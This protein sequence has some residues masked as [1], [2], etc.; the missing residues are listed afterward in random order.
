[1]KGGKCIAKVEAL[2]DEKVRLVASLG[3]HYEVFLRRL[4]DAHIVCVYRVSLPQFVFVSADLADIAS[5]LTGLSIPADRQAD[6]WQAILKTAKP[7]AHHI[8]RPANFRMIWPGDT[9]PEPFNIHEIDPDRTLAPRAPLSYENES[10]GKVEGVY[11]APSMVTIAAPDHCLAKASDI[12]AALTEAV[13]KSALG[14]ASGLALKMLRELFGA[15]LPEMEAGMADLP[16]RFEDEP[17]WGF[18][19][20]LSALGVGMLRM[21][22]GAMSYSGD[23]LSGDAGG[24]VDQALRTLAAGVDWSDDTA[25]SYQRFIAA[26]GRMVGV[27]VARAAAR[28][29]NVPVE[30]GG[31]QIDQE[32]GTVLVS[33]NLMAAQPAEPL[34]DIL[35][36]WRP[37]AEAGPR[38]V[39]ELIPDLQDQSQRAQQ[40]AGGP[41]SVDPR[42]PDPKRWVD[43]VALETVP[44]R[45]GRH[46]AGPT[47]KYDVLAGIISD[48]AL[49][50][51]NAA[52]GLLPTAYGPFQF[53]PGDRDRAI[54]EADT[55]V[56]VYQGTAQPDK[57]PADDLIAVLQNDLKAVGIDLG[58]QDK[59]FYAY[60]RWSSGKQKYD[61]KAGDRPA[62]DGGETLRKALKAGNTGWAVREFQLASRY[63]NHVA[64]RLDAK[65]HYTDRLHVVAR[66]NDTSIETRVAS[67]SP[68]KNVNG[69]LRLCEA[70]NLRRWR[71]QRLRYP[72]VVVAGSNDD[73]H[74]VAMEKKKISDE[75][76]ITIPKSPVENLVQTDQAPSNGYRMYVVDRSGYFGADDQ[77]QVLAYY[78]TGGWG[79][80]A[81]GKNHPTVDLTPDNILGVP[82][83]D[84]RP[85]TPGPDE[86]E[87]ERKERERRERFL[88]AFRVLAAVGEVEARG[89]F[90]G[91][92]AYDSSVFSYPTFHHTLS[93]PGS[94]LNNKARPG[95][96]SPLIRWLQAP[97]DVFLKSIYPDVTA[98]TLPDFPSPYPSEQSE[99][100]EL[101]GK[102][103]DKLAAIYHGAF[104]GFGVGASEL[105][106]TSERTGIVTIS[107]LTEVEQADGTKID[108][109]ADWNKQSSAQQRRQQA[110]YQSYMQWFRTWH[111]IYRF[112][113]PLRQ[114]QALRAVLFAYEMDWIKRKLSGVTNDF[115][116]EKGRAVYVRLAVRGSPY[117]SV[118]D[119]VA[120]VRRVRGR[121]N[122]AIDEAAAVLNAIQNLANR[123]TDA[124]KKGK[125]LKL[126]ES[127]QNCRDYSATDIGALST[128]NQSVTVYEEVRNDVL[129]RLVL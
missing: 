71:F 24:E 89:H 67:N 51:L 98:D 115:R 101:R 9:I 105:E 82:A 93:L 44:F 88:S 54:D 122:I 84:W 36:L 43:L 46:L 53:L 119:A 113:A 117:F 66:H 100:E 17:D 125:I 106:Q 12:M 57:R 1:M 26:A 14:L 29:Q 114:D 48:D 126:H 123:E 62:S 47:S 55:G 72:V 28:L 25:E 35:G 59:G 21:G 128:S 5:S 40:V 124:E 81:S 32:D 34:K 103:K 87:T 3:G 65:P 4:P 8:L 80:P 27:Y 118:G 92:N 30:E 39:T 70:E 78:G 74:G 129:R 58:L 79:G 94:E 77:A 37:T 95:L 99:V 69:E 96:M 85:G 20:F 97:D 23:P 86:T 76:T 16:K 112:I 121:R 64:E 75:E 7:V 49:D 56:P 19:G 31:H 107:G 127:T 11:L 104:G 38:A 109:S 68:S 13:Q 63:P 102:L 6:V 41:I 73:P 120:A 111:W 50:Y 116:T 33:G 52:F 15:R 42:L 45:T 60:R 18:D 108:L 10:T 61:G 110:V 91:L 83:A 90:D 22:F 2:G